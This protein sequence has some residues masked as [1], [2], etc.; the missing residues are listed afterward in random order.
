MNIKALLTIAS[1]VIMIVIGTYCFSTIAPHVEAIKT[2]KLVPFKVDDQKPFDVQIGGVHNIL[3][4]DQ[5]Q[6][7]DFRKGVAFG[8]IEY[9]FNLKYEAGQLFV[10]AE[11]KNI[12][13]D[14]VAKIAD[15][16]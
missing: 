11:I 8:D 6:G 13:G 15:N 3:T 4:V 16:Q 7:F 12:N 14:V 2:G 1:A 10:S 5:L 9:P